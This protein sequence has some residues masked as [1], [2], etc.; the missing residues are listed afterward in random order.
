MLATELGYRVEK[1]GRSIVLVQHQENQ[2]DR[3]LPK[4]LE[5][6]FVP[7]RLRY[8]S[9]YR[10]F[11]REEWNKL[12]DEIIE[13]N[14]KRC[15]ICGETEGALTLDAVWNYDDDEHIQRLDS[16]IFLCEMCH[17]TKHFGLVKM[18]VDR[19]SLDYNELIDHFCKVNNCSRE[20]FEENK[21]RALE[22]WERR[23]TYKWKRDLGKYELRKNRTVDLPQT[24]TQQV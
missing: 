18:L 17:C 23:S 13:K 16:F 24:R 11:S 1:V 7:T 5:I 9:F 8:S 10:V 3:R 14:G 22:V 6:E 21:S 20:E 12:R 4:K 19:G 15:Q 2:Q